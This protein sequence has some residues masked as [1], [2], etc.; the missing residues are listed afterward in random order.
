MA[1]YR[2]ESIADFARQ[3]AFAPVHARLGQLI[4]AEN[5]L[6]E[7]EPGKGYPYAFVVFR[8][9][10]YHPKRTAT[11]DL[12]TGIALQHDLGQ[13][14]E[15]VSETLW[16]DT[17]DVS[18]PVLMIDDVCE[19]F[20]VTSKT[21]QR[22]RRKGLPARRFTFP[23]G[24]RRVGFLVSSVERYIAAHSED[25]T[26]T[27]NFT[28]LSSGDADVILR[29]ARRLAA[30]SGCAIEEVARRIAHRMNRSAL[31]V[32]HTLREHDAR[33][34]EEAIIPLARPAVGEEERG[35]LARAF[36][37]GESLARLARD[38]GR[39][40]AAV[41]RAV[42]DERI[43]R[44]TQ[45]KQKFI[46]DT[47]YH[48][49]HAREAIDEMVRA[50]ELAATRA[51][52]E[53]LPRDL[54]AYFHSLYRTPL[55]T[56][57]RERAMFL[58]LNFHK[59]QFVAARR[60]LEPASARARDIARLERYLK[61]ATETKN[62]IV[63]ANLRLVVSVARKHLRPGVDLMEMISEGNITLMRAADSFDAHK[64]NKFSTYATLALMKGYARSVPLMQVARSKA[65]RGDEV[66][67]SIAD[68]ALPGAQRVI[69][70]DQLRQL[71][72]H[73]EP[74]ER[75]ALLTAYEIEDPRRRLGALMPS[76]AELEESRAL[77]R[78]RLRQIERRAMEKLRAIAGR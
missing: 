63:A 10:G 18:E 78:P 11:G 75:A 32:M 34:A 58:K 62:A 43:E 57:G 13:L 39:T 30:N 24:K 6:F 16:L 15:E 44:L 64:G 4:A 5:L 59:Y 48:Q 67:P 56:P 61:L 69:D 36:K 26:S 40:R 46:D 52:D 27:T 7:L 72:K 54:P 49:A 76:E 28:Q 77:G 51:G 9:T 66:L 31:T 73:L 14:V 50:E 55:L 21:I 3:L 35:E 29:S 2:I 22:W 33:H 53:R 23:D 17:K 41:Y 20:G 65:G 68:A 38:C 12:I 8:I 25:A 74:A 70:V 45:R 19:R 47:L 42:L 60:K 71:L 1:R 37:R